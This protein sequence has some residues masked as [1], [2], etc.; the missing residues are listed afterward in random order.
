MWYEVHI[1]W[2]TDGTHVFTLF[3]ES[4][5]QVSQITGTDSTWTVGGIGYD[6]YLGDGGTVYIDH[7]QIHSGREIVSANEVIDSFEDSDLAEYSFDRGSSG[8]SVV[9]DPTYAGSS[10]LE[11][12]GTNTEMISTSGL[13]HY[14]VAGDVFSCWVRGTGGAD[15]INFT[16]GVQDH[17]NRYYVRV[18]FANN[19]L[20]LFRYEN[21][22]GTPLAE[23]GSASLSED[24][25]YNVEVDWRKTG[26]HTVTLYDCD[27]GQ[28][29]QITGDD[30]TWTSGGIGY[31][32]YLGSGGTV[33]F[34]YV[35]IH[36]SMIDDFEDGDLAEYGGDT[37]SFDVQSSTILEG[38][39]VLAGTS[40][41]AAVAH[42]DARTPRGHTYTCSIV[43]GSGSGAKPGLLTA[44]QNPATPL[45]D[46]Y[47]LV[48]D[49][50]NDE[51]SLYRRS[52]GQSTLLG[53]ESVSIKEGTEYQ[54]VVELRD[55]VVLG[56]LQDASG[57][58]LAGVAEA[59]TTH[60]GG[61]AGT[62]LTGGAP[63]YFDLITKEPLWSG[64]LD[65]FEE[66]SV[67]N[68]VGDTEYYSVQ[69]TTV[70][71]GRNTLECTDNY[72]KLVHETATTERGKV[73][74]CRMMAGDESGAE[75]GLLTCVQD[76]ANPMVDCYWAKIDPSNDRL[77][78][79]RRENDAS[80]KLDEV[81]VTVSE[82]TEYQLWIALTESEVQAV[83]V[84]KHRR[85]LAT[86]DW[87]QDGTFDSGT[88][89]FYTGGSGA[90]AYYD[91]VGEYPMTFLT[92]TEV[93][94]TQSVAKDALN[95]T[96]AQE[97]LAELGDPSTDPTKATQWN[98]YP[99]DGVIGSHLI[100]IPMEY[101]E[102]E[103]EYDGDTAKTA[104]ANLDR[105]TMSSSLIQDLSDD[106]G[107]PTSE[108]ARLVYG[109][110]MSVPRF[111][112]TV[113]DAEQ[114]D[115]KSRINA[116]ENRSDRPL[117]II[118]WNNN[119]GSYRA[120]YYDKKYR[121]NESTSSVLD[122]TERFGSPRCE[123]LKQ[124]C[125]GQKLYSGYGNLQLAAT[126]IGAIIEPTLFL[127]ALC[128]KSAFETYITREA[129]KRK[130]ACK[131]YNNKCRGRQ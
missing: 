44:V 93:S 27:G 23:D 21:G 114:S 53:Q 55:Y 120:A 28:V 3:D 56:E 82:G 15:D 121:V 62:Y 66:G 80:T 25:W 26:T 12:S 110:D 73:Y 64:F 100:V 90:P 101:G 129:L 77:A 7:T 41:P 37:G 19:D 92:T 39:S 102:I 42:T 88:F 6:A 117:G 68:Y 97:I 33:Y 127:E 1:D 123:N 49:S 83:L 109:G 124:L 29:A 5:N 43:A 11:L 79:Y 9:S 76:P 103:V 126:C 31:D 14:P 65:N 113:T 112:R 128:A 16:Y 71:R 60:F 13:D 99:T 74:S 20:F 115:V 104:A 78:L 10:V 4:G 47:A 18:D 94:T 95:T 131:R 30:S 119:G 54:L 50:V 105:S 116:E 35:A 125:S 81:N 40:A 72:R 57:N 36:L 34:D 52:D 32:A 84:S 59:D 96:Y 70:L 22:S 91:S 45:Q 106:F 122:A 67:S 51:L 17:D 61:H 130:G 87:V 118:V 86:T 8:A 75:P 108:E 24:T 85:L 58:E 38:D 98:G 2:Q 89:G 69:S 111:V 63:G 107:W 46:C 48:A